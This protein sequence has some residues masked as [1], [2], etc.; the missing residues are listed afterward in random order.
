[1][2]QREEVSCPSCLTCKLQSQDL[3]PST[4]FWRALCSAPL[5]SFVSHISAGLHLGRLSVEEVVAGVYTAKRLK[6]HSFSCCCSHYPLPIV[7]SIICTDTLTS[8][9]PPLYSL[10]AS[11]TCLGSFWH[12]LW[13]Y[14]YF[15]N[16]H[17]LSGKFW[18]LGGQMWTTAWP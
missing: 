3:K 9:K 7:L 14:M 17:L 12:N 11:R 16:I 2:A 15:A 5:F 8:I 6:N 4:W 10:R 13:L 18:T 1:M